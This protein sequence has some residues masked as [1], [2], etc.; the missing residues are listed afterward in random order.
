MGRLVRF[1]LVGGWHTIGR[2]T[3]WCVATWTLRGQQH[4]PKAMELHKTLAIYSSSFLLSF[5]L[6]PCQDQTDPIF[7]LRSP[8]HTFSTMLTLRSFMFSLRWT[9]APVWKNLHGLFFFLVL[10]F[11]LPSI[12]SEIMSKALHFWYGDICMVFSALAV[13]LR[14]PR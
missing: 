6:C 5:L 13:S 10:P 3:Q 11:L 8:A 9:W 2:V 4:A 12:L 14:R 7:M 1:R